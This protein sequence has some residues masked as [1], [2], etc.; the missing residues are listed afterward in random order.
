MFL[1]NGC[2][3]IAERRAG[4]GGQIVGQKCAS[5]QDQPQYAVRSTDIQLNLSA[6]LRT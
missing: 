5:E 6:F 2:V 1:L 3:Q 4:A